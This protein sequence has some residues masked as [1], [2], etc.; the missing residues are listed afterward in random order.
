MIYL[1]TFDAVELYCRQIDEKYPV[2]VNGV[3]VST[4]PQTPY[5]ASQ[6]LLLATDNGGCFRYL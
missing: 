3:W 1:Q 5:T 4:N 2:D 6:L